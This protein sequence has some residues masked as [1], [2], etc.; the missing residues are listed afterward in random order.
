MDV[1]G[2]LGGLGQHPADEGPRSLHLG[3]SRRCLSRRGRSLFILVDLDAGWWARERRVGI[4]SVCLICVA[5]TGTLAFIADALAF[6]GRHVIPLIWRDVARAS[7]VVVVAVVVVV[8]V[9]VISIVISVV[10]SVVVPVVSGVR[11]V[12]AAGRVVVVIII[13]VVVVRVV[14]VVVTG[15]VAVVCMVRSATWVLG[16]SFIQDRCIFR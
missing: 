7:S 2:T 12:G 1:G 3:T 13:V 6:L 4:V 5:G 8:G 10:V 9:A 15:A 16:V 11:V 14:V